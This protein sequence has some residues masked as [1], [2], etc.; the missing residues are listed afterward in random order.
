MNWGLKYWYGFLHRRSLQEVSADFSEAVRRVMNPFA[1]LAET[2][3]IMQHLS[4]AKN[5]RDWHEMQQPRTQ[6][7]NVPSLLINSRDDPMAKWENTEHLMETI[8]S[9]PNLVLAEMNCG[10]HFCKYNFSGAVS[11]HD[12]MIGEFVLSSWH[13]LHCQQAELSKEESFPD[14]VRAA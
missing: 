2:Y 3:S 12:A 6:D 10:A 9:N 14:A 13:E 1:N 7:I 4:G 8:V 5:E 11:V